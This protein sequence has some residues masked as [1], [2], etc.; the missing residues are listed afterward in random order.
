[1]TLNSLNKVMTETKFTVVVIDKVGNSERFTVD[2]LA[3][4]DGETNVIKY[5][6]VRAKKNRVYNIMNNKA[7]GLLEIWVDLK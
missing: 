2:Y 4:D 1:M 5:L 7:T 6:D 3:K